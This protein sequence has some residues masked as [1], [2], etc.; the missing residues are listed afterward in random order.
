MRGFFA[1][2]SRLSDSE[3]KEMLLPRLWNQHDKRRDQ[4]D[5]E[6]L[7]MTWP[8]Y[9]ST[10]G[11][12]TGR[13][14]G[15]W[16]ACLAIGVAALPPAG[17]A[18]TIYL[19]NGHKIIAQVTREDAKQVVY[20]IPG[21]ELTI[22]RT[23]VDHIEKSPLPEPEAASEN[24]ASRSSSA[25]EVPLPASP[26]A[27][28]SPEDNSPVI[29]D[30]AVDEAYLQGLEEDMLHTSAPDKAPLLKQAFQ[31]AGVFLVRKGDADGAIQHYAEALKFFPNDLALT[32]AL[33]YLDV[34]ES[35]YL[36]AI[37][38]L[39]PASDRYPE[40]A[41]IL[42]LLGSA[43]YGMENLDQALSAWNKALALHDD[44]RLR[45]AIDKAEREQAVAGSYQELRS[46]HFLLR[47]EGQENEKLSEEVLNSLEG[48]FR[49]LVL[50]L[51]YF[52]RETIVVLLYPNQAFQDITRSPKWVGALNDGKIRVPVSGLNQ[53][54]TELARVLKHELTHSFV[55]QI[56]VGRCPTWFNEGL[57]QL[58]EG[59]TSASLGTTLARAL[60]TGDL[61]AFQ[62]LEGPFTSLPPELIGLVYGKSLAALEYLR[63][64]Y[65]MGEIRRLLRALP[66]NPDLNS[67]FQDKLRLSY[68]AFEQEVGNYVV[69]R[70]GA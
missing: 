64:T 66:S 38:L 18:D 68:P 34:T 33:G 3:M 29:K 25:R 12:S 28:T 32:L 57:A 37:D 60:A 63:D 46:E 36:E 16:L 22:P 54:D 8:R 65:G 26:L 20:E 55:R 40:S 30:G 1:Q 43:F 14:L 7:G 10:L 67:L 13:T 70:Y 39:L 17:L 24:S 41:D 6:G 45:A 50:D 2:F 49:D 9:F 69:K 53:M 5:S 21:G 4:H 35:H 52:P 48:S 27:E 15:L 44:P 51:D 23:I 47:Y 19:K 62:A 56:T 58:E 11:Y 31:Q 61:P 59:A 42:L